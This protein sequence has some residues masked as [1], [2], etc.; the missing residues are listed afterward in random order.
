MIIQHYPLTYQ[1]YQ[2]KNISKPL[3]HR[4]SLAVETIKHY[5]LGI[6]PSG[7]V[8]KIKIIKANGEEVLLNV[9]KQVNGAFE[10]YQIKDSFN[11]LI[12]EIDIKINKFLNYDRLEFSTD[13]SH[14]FVNELRNYSN[15]RTP[16]Y[17]NGLK[18]YKGIGTRL[19]QIAQ[20]RSDEA[21]CN[22]NIE[23]IAKNRGEV[24]EFYKNLGFAQPEIITRFTNPY[25][26]H[27][28]PLAKE[29]LSKKYG[30]L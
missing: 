28:T 26:L 21:L 30:G 27:L 7:Y 4:G 24:L 8:G 18:E 15:P 25:K 10:K 22:G 29:P 13:P 9:E 5:N 19:L 16:Y 23:L 12:G 6:M 17:K 20:R 2:N 3:S 11:N 1:V 14:V